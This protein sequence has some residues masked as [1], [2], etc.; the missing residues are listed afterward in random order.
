MEII[1]TN[2]S[3]LVII[4]DSDIVYNMYKGMCLLLIIYNIENT[5]KIS[6]WI[7]NSHSKKKQDK[8]L[9]DCI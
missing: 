8:K 5:I 6:Q 7:P 2:L 9:L 3:R 1:T 4:D